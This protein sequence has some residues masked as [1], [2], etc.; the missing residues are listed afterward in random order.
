MELSLKQIALNYINDYKGW[1]SKGELCRLAQEEG[2][3]PENICR[4]CRELVN[5]GKIDVSYY[6]GK[7]H[8]TLARYAKLG[9]D[10]PTPPKQKVE[11]TIINGVPIAKLC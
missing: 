7:K 6:K 2:Y 1:V 4:R 3:S 11:I 8:Q 5:E 9:E 10:T